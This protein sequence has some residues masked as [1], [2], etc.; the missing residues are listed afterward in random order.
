M[1]KQ[2]HRTRI[3]ICGITSKEAAQAAVDAGADA[4]GL[5][6]VEASA[7][8][9]DHHRAEMISSSLPPWIDAVRVFADE[10]PD[11]IATWPGRHLQLHGNEDE[12]YIDDLRRW[13][14]RSS[15]IRGFRF[16]G[17][18]V[19][20]WMDCPSVLALLIDGSA[21]GEGRAFDHT[22]LA[23]MMDGIDKPVILAGGLTP[24]NIGEAVQ[25]VH[26][27]A[28]DVSSGVEASKGVKDP[29][30]IFAFCEAVRRADASLVPH[31]PRP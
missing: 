21:G 16:N 17:D 9:V 31:E 8:Y 7:R 14:D 24:E 13:C 30:L 4:I 15:I 22:E 20:R 26:P 19:Q 27:Y 6:A 25:T 11:E 18:A 23:A 12:Q 2:V 5:V 1:K 10:P 3:K 29:E 28:V